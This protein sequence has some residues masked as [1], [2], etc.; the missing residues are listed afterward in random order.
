[1]VA[2]RPAFKVPVSILTLIL[3]SWMLAGLAELSGSAR[4]LHHDRLIEG[5]MPLW[6]TLILFVVTWQLMIAAMMLPSSLPL[7]RLFTAAAANQRRAALVVAVFLSGYI[8]VWTVFGLFAFAGDLALH[9]LVDSSPWLIAHAGA[10]PGTILV[11]AGAFQFS[12]LK[13]QCLKKC[14]L[15]ANFLL[16]QYKRGALAAFNLG[17]NHG[18]FCLGC[19]W[20]LMLVGFAAG[21]ANLLWMGFLTAVMVYEKTGKYGPEGARVIGAALFVGGAFV[22]VHPIRVFLVGG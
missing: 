7:I 13:E 15:P 21:A 9:R 16:Q 22:I 17:S 4:L 5:G 14:R 20:A 2:T 11:L 10:I 6:S 3:A 18:L 8:A 12:S 19:C 1:M